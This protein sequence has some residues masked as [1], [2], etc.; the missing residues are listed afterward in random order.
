[1]PTILV[2]ESDDLFGQYLTAMLAREGYEVHAPPS[3][4]QVRI[5]LAAG[6]FDAVITELYMPDLDGIEVVRVVKRQFPAVPVIGVT[7][8]PALDPCG[9][10]MLAFG[11]EAVLSKP[12]DALPFLALLRRALESAA[13][14]SPCELG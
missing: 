12:F 4:H 11:A 10:A 7:G 14:R 5:A 1:M 9:K 2:I 3:S 13:M 6:D 8:G